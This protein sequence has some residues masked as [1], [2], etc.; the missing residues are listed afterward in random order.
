MSDAICKGCGRAVYRK[1][2]DKDERCVLCP[3]PPA[4]EKA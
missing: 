2:L 1:D 3:K 4:K